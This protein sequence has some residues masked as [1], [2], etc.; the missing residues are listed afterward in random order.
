MSTNFAVFWLPSTSLNRRKQAHIY[1]VTCLKSWWVSGWNKNTVLLS[2]FPIPVSTPWCST[3]W[4][5]T[6]QSFPGYK[7]QE[8]AAAGECRRG[9]DRHRGIT[10]VYTGLSLCSGSIHT[11]RQDGPYLIQADHREWH[12]LTLTEAWV[13]NTNTLV[14]SCRP[15]TV[16]ELN[17]PWHKPPLSSGIKRKLLQLEQVQIHCSCN[18]CDCCFRTIALFEKVHW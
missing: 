3:D 4:G 17:I 12:S 2:C 5:S 7:P 16:A 6:P 15:S 8:L 18:I 13:W 10:E 14:L 1:Q 11:A 9:G